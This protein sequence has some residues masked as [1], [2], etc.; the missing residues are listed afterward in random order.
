MLSPGDRFEG[1]VVEAP[2]GHGGYAT[3]YRAHDAACPDRAVALKVL[4]EHHRQPAQIAQLQ[5]GVDIARRLDHPHIIKVYECGPG[6]LAIE[7]IDGGTVAKLPRLADRLVAL[8]QI[9]DA[10]DFAHQRGVVHC[11]VKPTNILVSVP[12]S[13][14]GAVL[15]DFGIAHLMA[16]DV[17]RRPTHVVASLPYAAP[18]LLRGQ[19]PS[20]ATDE[21]ALACTA[22]ELITGAPPFTAKTSF[23]LV[24]EQL[25]APPPRLS[26]KVDWLPHAF[27]SMMS[28]A[29]AK[30]PDNR[31]VSCTE[32]IALITRAV[33]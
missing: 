17:G 21:Y 12:F 11:D 32:F 20:A 23:D 1:Y 4:D 10:L 22:F 31:Y 28:K 2:L 16:A 27:D 7:L 29:L 25:H 8:A 26:R 5:R 15:I 6:W 14:R 19:T 18:E 13:L 24:D 30:N 9:A 33:S 3:V